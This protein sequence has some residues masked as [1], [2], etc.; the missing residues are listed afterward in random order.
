MKINK[1]LSLPVLMGL[2]TGVFILLF[3]S[4]K[5]IDFPRGTPTGGIIAGTG[6]AII[7]ISMFFFGFLLSI[8]IRFFKNQNKKNN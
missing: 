8:I 3:L 6:V 7:I 2:F 4:G 5:I 1:R